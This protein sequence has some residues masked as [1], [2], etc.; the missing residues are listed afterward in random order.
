MSIKTLACFDREL[1]SHDKSVI[2]RKRAQHPPFALGL[3]L[4][5]EPAAYGSNSCRLQWYGSACCR[6]LQRLHT[7]YDL[8]LCVPTFPEVWQ[9]DI[10]RRNIKATVRRAPF[11]PSLR[12][13]V[14]VRRRAGAENA[15]WKT[16][17]NKTCALRT[18]HDISKERCL[19][20]PSLLPHHFSRYS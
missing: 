11:R 16:S 10:Q 9:K 2:R 1:K 14:V 20:I 5:A 8:T 17:C 19:H 15:I 13:I 6:F 7:N 4:D 12:G 3:R 18:S